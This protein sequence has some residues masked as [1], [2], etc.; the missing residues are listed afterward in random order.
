MNN[1]RVSSA[2]ARATYAALMSAA[3][4]IG[5]TPARAGA[6]GSDVPDWARRAAID[7]DS[8]MSRTYAAQQK[9]R[10][11]AEKELKKI[12]YKHFGSI[13]NVEIRQAGIAKIREFTD[14]AIFPSLVEIFRDERD[15][16]RSA[17]LDHLSDQHSDEGDACLAWIATHDASPELRASATRKVASRVRT[18]GNV[19]SRIALV[20]YGALRSP[21]E[22]VIA[23]GAQLAQ[24]IGMY[25]AIPWLI[26]SQ[27]GSAPVSSGES[28]R[29]GDLAWIMVGKQIAFVS[30]LTPVVADSAVAFDPQ[31]S[32]ITEGVLLRVHDAAV[33]TYRYEVH[34]AL[35]DLSERDWGRPTRG[36]GWNQDGWRDWYAKDYLPFRK[37]RDRELAAAKPVE[38]PK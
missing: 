19:S 28:D 2:A 27:L 12:R 37:Q 16:V 21:N 6:Q 26:S 31:L 5:G 11:E 20:V 4:V 23:A 14:P 25:D 9:K 24:G 30:D 8:P 36:L 18:T 10:L 7:P 29:G 32:V 13:N 22:A 35:I 1:S 15:D 38:P 3:I 17:V 34:N 33:L